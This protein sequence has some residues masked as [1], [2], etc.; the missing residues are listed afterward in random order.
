MTDQGGAGGGGGAKRIVGKSKESFHDAL[1]Q[2]AQEA[3]RHAGKDALFH[4]VDHQVVVSNPRV[5]EYRIV[6]V[7]ADE[8]I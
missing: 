4:V 2:A 1:D 3:Y 7:P 5:G 6:L 8:P